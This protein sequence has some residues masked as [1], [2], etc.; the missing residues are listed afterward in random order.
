MKISQKQKMLLENAVTKEN[1]I[2]PLPPKNP[3]VADWFL[4]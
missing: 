4:R 2:S 1:L 3:Q